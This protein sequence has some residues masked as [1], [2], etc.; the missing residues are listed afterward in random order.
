MTKKLLILIC[1]LCVGCKIID[2]ITGI[3][4]GASVAG[5]VAPGIIQ[6][7]GQV[8]PKDILVKID[9]AYQ[10]YDAQVENIMHN[11]GL[12]PKERK[13]LIKEKTKVLNG[14]TKAYKSLLANAYGFPQ[15]LTDYLSGKEGQE[16]IGV[17]AKALPPPWNEV[18]PAG[19][20]LGLLISTIVFGRGRNRFKNMAL[21]LGNSIEGLKRSGILDKEEIREATKNEA[22]KL[23]TSVA[24]LDKF[25]RAHIKRSDLV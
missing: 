3:G 12:T 11:V 4:A 25:Y 5:F 16:F 8:K 2:V 22:S 6:A 21:L 19:A 9:L 17:I 24:D 1:L 15:D 14:R 23:R 13:A 20:S 10:E 18:L 7:H